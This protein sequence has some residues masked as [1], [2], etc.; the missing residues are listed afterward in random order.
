MSRSSM[1]NGSLSAVYDPAYGLE[2]T[3]RV[4][5]FTVKIGPKSFECIG[6]TLSTKAKA[7]LK[8][9]PKGFDVS[10]KKINYVGI[11]SGKKESGPS[12]T[13]N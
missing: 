1:A 8:K 11:S 10:F 5:S 6:K 7:A 12:I 3:V 13:I 2:S 4:R 9:A